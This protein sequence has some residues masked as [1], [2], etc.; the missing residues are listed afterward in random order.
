MLIKI[1]LTSRVFCDKFLN[2]SNSRKIISETILFYSELSAYFSAIFMKYTKIFSSLVLLVCTFAFSA[3]HYSQKRKPATARKTITVVSGKLISAPP[4]SLSPELQRRVETFNF[5]WQI[6]SDNYFDQTFSGLDWHK[7]QREYQPRVLKTTSDAQLHDILQEMIGRLDRSHLAI[8]PPEVYTAIETAKAEAKAKREKQNIEKADEAEDD[9]EETDGEDKFDFTDYSAKYGIG[10]DLYLIENEFVVTRVEAGSSAEKAGIKTGYVI[11]KINDVS[12]AE[13]LKQIDLHFSKIRNVKKHLSAEVVGY[14]LDGSEESFVALSVSPQIGQTK[15]LNVR[16]ERLKGESVSLGE[17][18]PEQFLK[19]EAT[20]LNEQI[21]YIKFNAFALPVIEKFCA[22]LTTLKD[23]QAIIIDLRGNTGGIIG[24]LIGLGGMLTETSLDLGTSI[25]KIGRENMTALSKAKNYKGKVVFLVDSQTTSAAEIFAAGLQENNRALVVGEKTAGEALPSVSVSLPTGA[26]LLYPIANY[27]TRGG[28]FL[29]GKGV[30]PNY[31][32]ALDRKSLLDGK[33]AQLETAVKIIKENTAFPK[34]LTAM[35]Q[36]AEK[37]LPPPPPVPKPSAAMKSRHLATVTVQAPP[38]A[39]SPPPIF[40][41]SEKAVQLIA[42][43]V[44]AIGGEEALSR[45]ISY[46]LKGTT[47]ISYRGM[48]LEGEI[49]ILRQKNERYAEIM[50]SP[51]SGEIRQIY[52]G[53]KAFMQTAYGIEREAAQTAK[54]EEIE[55]FAPF[56]NLIKKDFF[57]SLDYL[58]AYDMLGKKAHVI[59]AI[60]A[61][62]QKIAFA[63]SVE[64]KMLVSYTQQNYVVLFDDYRP[65]EKVRLPFVFNRGSV[66]NIRLDEIKLNSP[67]AESNFAVSENCYDR[68]N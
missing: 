23:K 50:N 34:P 56:Y 14:L 65:V 3:N 67:I 40:K 51:S 64:T 21:G 37:K 28:N 8:I 44:N 4:R 24:S 53:K 48:K 18:Y 6:I 41:K 15:E 19:F 46:D 59:E 42:E 2:T 16:R 66:M 29:E 10:V 62:D 54:I 36:F 9:E 27:Q 12:L 25:Y 47:E 5:A 22:A 43:F 60:T 17:N 39:P 68:A 20:A 52:D 63:F 45:V 13:L 7:I 33:D 49:S 1:L 32:V 35:S 11:E 58:G 61:E 31:T 38:L 26:V 57:K 55:L 30:E